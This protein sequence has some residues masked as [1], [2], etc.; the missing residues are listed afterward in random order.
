MRYIKKISWT[1]DLWNNIL[2]D[3][4]PRGDDCGYCPDGLPGVKVRKE[5]KNKK[6]K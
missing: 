3:K 1:Q 6:F 4:G 2:G 5:Q